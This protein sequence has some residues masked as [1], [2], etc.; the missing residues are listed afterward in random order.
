MESL[1]KMNIHVIPFDWVVC[2]SLWALKKCELFYH[3][4]LSSNFKFGGGRKIRR[5]EAKDKIQGGKY[6]P[7]KNKKKEKKGL[8][9]MNRIKRIF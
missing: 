1:A 7:R 8:D 5:H 3:I 4:A 6:Q 2:A 9:R